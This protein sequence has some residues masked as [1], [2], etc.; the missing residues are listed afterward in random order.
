MLD[1]FPQIS[2]ADTY[3]RPADRAR[4]LERLQQDGSVRGFETQRE[5]QNGTL[6]WVRL[7]VTP[8]TLGGE[9]VFL[10]VAEDIS[11]RVRVK[12][13]LKEYSER[14]DGESS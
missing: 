4:L 12:D 2:V 1:D 13:A 8:F 9:P 6:Y 10:T 14:L 5:R 11:D 7:A 3:H